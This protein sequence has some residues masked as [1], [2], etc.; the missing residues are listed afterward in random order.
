[1]VSTTTDSSHRVVMFVW[2]LYVP[3]NNVSV[4]SGLSHRFQGITSTFG[5]VNVSCSMIQHGDLSED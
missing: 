2:G 1:M 3:V 5:E 4:M